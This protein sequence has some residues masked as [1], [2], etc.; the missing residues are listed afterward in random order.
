MGFYHAEDH[1]WE[2]VFIVIKVKV[3]FFPLSVQVPPTGVGHRDE[4]RDLHAIVMGQWAL[5]RGV[6]AGRC[7]HVR[8][9]VRWDQRIRPPR[10]RIVKQA[11]VQRGPAGQQR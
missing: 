11:L 10:K 4:H 8:H 2:I 7:G 6:L 5:S 3:L 9:I 1:L